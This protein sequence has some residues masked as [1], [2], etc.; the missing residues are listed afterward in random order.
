MITYQVKQFHIL[1]LLWCWLGLNFFLGSGLLVALIPFFFKFLLVD[2]FVILNTY[3]GSVYGSVP[4]N[5]NFLVNFTDI[6]LESFFI[7]VLNIGGNERSEKEGDLILL[8]FGIGEKFQRTIEDTSIVQSC[9]NKEVTVFYGR[10][11]L[12]TGLT[13]HQLFDL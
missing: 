13:T 6:P 10:R 8:C 7:E 5:L 3:I 12:V 1:Y 11:D 9:D 2:K 4:F